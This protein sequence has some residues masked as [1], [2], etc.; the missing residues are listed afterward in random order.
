MRLVARGRTASR[1]SV[2]PVVVLTLAATTSPAQAAAGD[3]DPTFGEGGIVRLD[4]VFVTGSVAVQADGRIVG[5]GVARG[6]SLFEFDWG[7]V[8]YTADGTVDSSFGSDGIVTTDF[9][10]DFDLAGDLVLQPDGKIVVTGIE[11]DDSG[12]DRDFAVARYNTDG[13]L[14]TGFAAD[15]TVTTDFGGTDDTAAMLLQPDGKIVVAG[16]ADNDL[17]LARYNTDGTLDAGFGNG[18]KV[19]DGLDGF[20]SAGA[21][22]RQDDGRLLVAGNAGAELMLA[23]YS[24]DGSLDTGFGVGGFVTYD[25]GVDAVYDGAAQSDGKI[26]VVGP[27]TPL[28]FALVRFHPDGTLDAAFGSGGLVT[29]DFYGDDD[30]PSAIE[31]Q[32]DGAILVAGLSAGAQGDDSFDEDFALARY[33]PDGTLDTGFGSDGLVTTD[34]DGGNEGASAIALQPDGRIL[35]AGAEALVRY[36]ADGAVTPPT[37]VVSGGQCLA[38]NEATGAVSLRVS[39]PNAVVSAISSNQELIPD[40]NLSVSGTGQDRR[41]GIVAAAARSGTATVTVAAQGDDGM[42]SLTIDVVVGTTDP[43]VLV[44]GEGPD[45]LFGLHGADM[46]H[47][48]GGADLLCG[49]NGADRLD[50]GDGDDGLFGQNGSDALSGGAAADHFSGGRGADVLVDLQRAEGDTTDGS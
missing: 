50:G 42:T 8:R 45:V 36:L 10:G 19:T 43:D 37:I 49:G 3:L 31:L 26:V 28:D 22:V 48:R 16:Q 40:A 25:L 46:L 4:R 38:Q 17:A 32:T 13:S 24:T 33:Q 12:A 27:M 15:G 29:T 23:R 9:G 34:I 47:G 35:L 30:I 11:G 1:A 14:D 2:L 7:L 18:G 5:A 39:S 41:L 20:Q 6:A 44:S 21:L